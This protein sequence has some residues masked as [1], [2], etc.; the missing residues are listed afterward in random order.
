MII[1]LT[2]NARNQVKEMMKEENDNV[3]LRFGIQGGGC[4]GLSY[5]LGFDDEINEELDVIE[6]INEIPVVFF[7]Q[8]VPIIEG[9]TIDFKQNMMGEALASRIQMLLFP[10]AV[11]LLSVQRNILDQ[12]KSAKY[13]DKV[14]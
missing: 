13:I 14:K 6:E 5:S 11:D 10:V 2:D 7:N 1:T 8:D 4:S 9:T 3:R 12:L